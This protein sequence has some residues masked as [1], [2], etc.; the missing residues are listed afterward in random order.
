[1]RM[2]NGVEVYEENGKI[3]VL[4]S[5]GYGA[6]WSTWNDER[7]AYD[8]RA[9]EFWLEHKDDKEL[10]EAVAGWNMND[11]ALEKARKYFEDCGYERPYMGGFKQIRMEWVS[12]G[13]KW[14][15]DEYDGYETLVRLRNAGFQQF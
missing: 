4:V 9:V 11:P 6:G 8:K 10:M 14:K 2:Y 1:M 5:P 12:P 7:L 15:I 3:G 13:E